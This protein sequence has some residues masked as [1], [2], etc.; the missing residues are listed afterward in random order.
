MK[1]LATILLTAAAVMTPAAK[2]AFPVYSTPGTENPV[3]IVSAAAGTTNTLRTYFVGK[4]G[5]G[6]TVSL[7][8]LVNGIDRGLASYTNQSATFGQVHNF[9]AITA[10][11]SIEYYITVADTGQTYRGDKS[12]NSDGIQH[13][14]RTNYSG[15]DF[16][17]LLSG[18]Y[19]G[20][21]DLT[22]GGD[23]NYTDFQFVS[24]TSILN[25]VPEPGTWAMMIIGFGA[26]GTVA[27]R[28]R[29]T[30]VQFA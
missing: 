7:G 11:D 26:V 3:S 21:E 9:G 15:T 28:R 24:T 20:A 17:F 12:L 5:A 4:G 18:G 27:R 23:F 1:L 29:R 10:G 22:G 13:F 14:F 8:A 16:G 30:T 6:Y 19:Y 25:S 2:A